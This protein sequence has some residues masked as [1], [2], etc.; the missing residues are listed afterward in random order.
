MMTMGAKV[1]P[2]RPLPNRCPR[3]SS[4]MMAHDTPTTVSWLML[5]SGA[6]VWMP[7]TADN[8]AAHEVCKEVSKA[9]KI[10]Q[11]KAIGARPLRRLVS[12]TLY[13][14]ALLAVLYAR[15]YWSKALVEQQRTDQGLCE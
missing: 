2:T 5:A 15:H 13:V 11:N 1:E 6:P 8:T 14:F 7:E 3:N 4:T 10:R 12:V 9:Q